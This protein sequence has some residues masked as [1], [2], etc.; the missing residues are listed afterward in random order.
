MTCTA[1]KCTEMLPPAV[2][3]LAGMARPGAKLPMS[4]SLGPACGYVKPMKMWNAKNV[5]KK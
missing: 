2:A 5:M 1:L 3:K 4:T